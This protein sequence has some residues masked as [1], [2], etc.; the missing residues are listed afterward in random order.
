MI[1]NTQHVSS[2]YCLVTCSAF[3]RTFLQEVIA[4]PFQFINI[5]IGIQYGLFNVKSETNFFV[6]HRLST[7]SCPC[8]TMGFS[9][10]ACFGFRHL[11]YG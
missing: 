1:K 6:C 11:R 3:F 7:A 5:T 9:F 10:F 2:A 8:P 4:I